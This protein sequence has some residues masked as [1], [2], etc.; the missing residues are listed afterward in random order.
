MP[1]AFIDP[2]WRDTPSST[3]SRPVADSV[4]SSEV[5]DGSLAEVDLSSEV[6]SRLSKPISIPSFAP[7]TNAAVSTSISSAGSVVSG[8]TTSVWPVVVRGQGNP[9]I[10]INDVLSGQSGT[11]RA[12]DTVKLSLLSSASANAALVATFYAQGLTLPWSVT[13]AAVTGPGPSYGLMNFADPAQ[14][15]LFAVLLGL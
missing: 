2:Y 15:G 11:V 4:G 14:S 10:L 8:D 12:G 1:G 7:V 13:T 5:V 9:Q 6:A 3:S